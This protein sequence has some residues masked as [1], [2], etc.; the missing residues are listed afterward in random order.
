MMPSCELVF[1]TMRAEEAL[2]VPIPT[3]THQ[4]TWPVFEEAPVMP[5]DAPKLL[6]E[7]QPI[8]EVPVPEACTRRP[9]AL[10]PV[11]P[12]VTLPVRALV[13]AT[14]RVP[15]ED[16]VV[17]ESPAA[18]VAPVTDSVEARAVA[19]D[20]VR[21]E[22]SVVAPEADRVVHPS[23]AS[24]VAPLTP[25]VDDKVAAPDADRVVQDVPARVLV[26]LTVR[27]PLRV[28]DPDDCVP[29]HVTLPVKFADPVT[30][31]VQPGLVCPPSPMKP[32]DAFTWRRLACV[33]PEPVHWSRSRES[34]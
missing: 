25:R 11:D 10:A 29:P 9:A 6:D 27:V 14:A 31:S 2:Y 19:P 5:I 16:R 23:A 4:P 26:P 33:V 13:P 28:S 1:S 15:E 24:V 8:E 7:S 21:V 20:T 30:S 12:T 18:V 22:E 32:L 17:A 34:V 3:P